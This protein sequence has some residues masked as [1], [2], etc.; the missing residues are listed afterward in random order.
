MGEAVEGLL[1]LTATCLRIERILVI[2]S[3]DKESWPSDIRSESTSTFSPQVSLC[4][5]T[6]LKKG[7]N[8]PAA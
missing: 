3:I 1:G 2:A 5:F 4:G 6:F 8:Y 7:Y